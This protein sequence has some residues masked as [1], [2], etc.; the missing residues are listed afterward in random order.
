[1]APKKEKEIDPHTIIHKQGSMFGKLANSR[2]RSMPR[3]GFGSSSRETEAKVFATA[4]H[5]AK[6]VGVHSPGPVYGAMSTVSGNIPKGGTRNIQC[7]KFSKS[8]RFPWH[9]KVSLKPR[10]EED[11]EVDTSITGMGKQVLATKRSMPSWG[12]GRATRDEVRKTVDGMFNKDFQYAAEYPRPSPGPAR[13]WDASSMGRQVAGGKRS[14]PSWPQMVDRR[15]RGGMGDEPP[16]HRIPAPGIYDIPGANGKQP[17]KT[18]N[19]MWKFGTGSRDALRK[20]YHNKEMEKDF[21]GRWTPGPAKIKLP[22]GNGKQADSRKRSNSA[23]GF[24]ST[25]RFSKI[26][27]PPGATLGLYSPGPGTYSPE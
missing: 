18:S 22:G 23:W 25:E 6:S 12:F 20:L 5:A 17:L 1:M 10:K 4:E 11:Q 16:G 27:G 3:P 21:F 24:G 7:H 14:N 26:G 13:C 8:E 15:F 19:P 2:R 9:A